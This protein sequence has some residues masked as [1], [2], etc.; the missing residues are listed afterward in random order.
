M[1]SLTTTHVSL[2]PTQTRV[3][4]PQLMPVVH[5]ML[6]F[7]QEPGSRHAKIKLGL[8]MAEGAAD[9]P[10]CGHRLS[11]EGYRVTRTSFLERV[12][13]DCHGCPTQFVVQETH[14]A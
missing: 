2:L 6:G 1:R 14:T 8:L 10:A 9:C 4:A 12:T 5:A 13:L 3:H 11:L 7:A